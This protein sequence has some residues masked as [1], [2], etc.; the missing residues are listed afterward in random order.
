ML[1]HLDQRGTDARS[2]TGLGQKLIGAFEDEVGERLAA[3]GRHRHHRDDP[4]IVQ[5]LEGLPLGVVQRDE[6]L[7]CGLRQCVRRVRVADAYVGAPRLRHSGN[8]REAARVVRYD[9]P[10]TDNDLVE[11]AAG[12]QRVGGLDRGQD[13]LVDR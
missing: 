1:P 12:E 10:V 11:R 9:L 5:G 6:R 7:V 2:V 8:P 3:H 13:L 4:S